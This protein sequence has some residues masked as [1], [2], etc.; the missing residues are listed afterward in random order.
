MDSSDE[1]MAL[2]NPIPGGPHGE[3][4]S[5]YTKDRIIAMHT[6]L[7]PGPGLN[8]LNAAVLNAGAKYANAFTTEWEEHNLWL[9]IRDMFTSASTRGTFGA[10]F[11]VADNPELIQ[12]LWLVDT[13]PRISLTDFGK[14]F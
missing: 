8:R 11:P 13:L 6:P 1:M 9:W 2:M 4:E 10:N 3:E 5:P 14:G 12:A 7:V